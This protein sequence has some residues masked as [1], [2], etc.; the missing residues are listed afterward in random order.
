[1]DIGLTRTLGLAAVTALM[2]VFVAQADAGPAREAAGTVVVDTSSAAPAIEPRW[3]DDANALA[4][5]SQMNARQIAAA[6]SELQAWRS[7]TVRAFAVAMLQQ[8]NALQHA[9]DSVAGAV[10]IT[11]AAPAVANDIAAAMQAQVDSMVSLRGGGLDRAYV[12]Q[13]IAS[14]QTM[15]DYLD[16]LSTLAERPEV[17]AVLSDASARSAA[18][19]TQAR[20]IEASFAAADSLAADSLAKKR[21]SVAAKRKGRAR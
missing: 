9:I 19:L 10:Q 6:Q 20:S 15:T 17:K 14:H 8:H 7:D 5:A 21:D 16:Q 13:Q 2:A 12:A 4:L 1:M 11:P 3:L 18:A